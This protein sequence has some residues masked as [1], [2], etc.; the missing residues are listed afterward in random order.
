MSNYY[1]SLYY[2]CYYVLSLCY[3]EDILVVIGFLYPQILITKFSVQFVHW[4][5]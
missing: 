4:P 2:S 5:Y 3:Q 1:L